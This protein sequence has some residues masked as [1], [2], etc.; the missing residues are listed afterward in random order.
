MTLRGSQESTVFRIGLVVPS[1]TYGGGVPA[2]AAFLCRVL[3]DSDLF[4][5]RLLSVPSSSRDH[6]SV[7][8]M[9]PSTWHRGPLVEEGHW[10]GRSYEHVGSVGAELEFQRYRPRRALTRRLR[11]CDLIQVVAGCPA[12]GLVA[13]EAG[14][15]LV[16]QVATLAAVERAERFRQEGGLITVWRRFMTRITAHLDR[17]GVRSADRIF[18]LN[19]WMKR[20]VEKW[21]HPDKVIVAPPGVDTDLFHPLSRASR[22]DTDYIL[23]VG[24]FD[25]RRKNVR[26]LFEAYAHLC[27]N[28]EDVP[29]MIL[30]GRTGPR[31]EDWRRAD[32]LEIRERVRF[33]EDVPRS[34][35]AELYR[36]ASLFVLASSEEGLGI[37]ILEAMASGLAVVSTATE[38]ARTAVKDRRTG[39]LTPVGDATALSRA[40]GRLLTDPGLRREMGREGHIRAEERFSRDAAGRRFLAAYLEILGVVDEQAQFQS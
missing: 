7:R 37:V 23:S 8:L 40:M 2:V 31:D 6:A 15:P 34:R 25:D 28:L 35:L 19:S 18:V 21:A 36:K 39:L 24:R 33:R 30:A 20:T 1:L 38:G 29:P 10:E 12:W 5:Y 4:E 16:L 26:L 14:R 11:E 27:R 17:E 13:R 9:R 3:D 32:E 22:S